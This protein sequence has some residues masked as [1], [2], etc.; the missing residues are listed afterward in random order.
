MLRRLGGLWKKIDA[1]SVPGDAKA[2]W[3]RA[4]DDVWVVGAAGMI[5]HFDGRAWTREESGTDETLVGIHGA[6]DTIWVIGEEGGLLR[7]KS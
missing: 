6:G 2:V 4:S 1:G 7:L 5:L 3:A